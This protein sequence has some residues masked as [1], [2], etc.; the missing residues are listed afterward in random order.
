MDTEQ[1]VAKLPAPF[2]FGEGIRGNNKKN[3]T[4]MDY[5]ARYCC[6]S[7]ALFRPTDV[8]YL[9]NK[10]SMTMPVGIL[11]CSA[12]AN[13]ISVTIFPLHGSSGSSV[14]KMKWGK[15]VIGAHTVKGTFTGIQTFELSGMVHTKVLPAGGKTMAMKLFKGQSKEFAV[16]K[17]TQDKGPVL[18]FLEIPV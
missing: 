5:K 9:E 8:S 2:I 17:I 3:A 18:S 11:K 10:V 7:T 13:E 6:K 14:I 4:C 12:S 1:T 16:I 15:I